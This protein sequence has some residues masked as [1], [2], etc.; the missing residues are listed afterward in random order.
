MAI[1]INRIFFLRGILLR[2]CNFTES[3]ERHASGG[4]VSRRLHAID[5]D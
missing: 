5:N 4:A 2:S 3:T 1:Q